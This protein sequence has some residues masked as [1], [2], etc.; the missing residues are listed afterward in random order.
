MI[1]DYLVVATSPQWYID[2]CYQQWFIMASSPMLTC[3]F[4]LVF[5]ST[6]SRMYQMKLSNNNI[7][8]ISTLISGIKKN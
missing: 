7:K 4:V 8:E 6:L 2:E 1:L 5:I 3:G